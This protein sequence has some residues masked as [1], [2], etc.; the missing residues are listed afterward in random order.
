MT[1]NKWN[2]TLTFFLVSLLI[3]SLIIFF[4]VALLLAGG[5]IYGLLYIS[6]LFGNVIGNLIN[7]MITDDTFISVS[8]LVLLIYLLLSI[9]LAMLMVSNILMQYYLVKFHELPVKNKLLVIITATNIFILI[10]LISCTLAGINLH[11]AIIKYCVCLWV[12]NSFYSVVLVI[13]HE[14][15]G[16]REKNGC[17]NTIVWLILWVFFLLSLYAAIFIFNIK[18]LN[19]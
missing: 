8:S 10:F 6:S 13:N 2:K 11:D 1:K 15:N 7:N 9:P 14:N 16:E 17:V 4:S 18:K 3:L 19:I 5:V 12:A